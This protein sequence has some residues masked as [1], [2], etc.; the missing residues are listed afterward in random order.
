MIVFDNVTKGFW[1]RRQYAPI[2]S[3]LTLTL[4]TGKSLAL[5]G[6]NGSGKTTLMQMIAGTMRPDEGEIWSDD[7]ISWPVGTGGSFHRN[8]TGAQNTRFVARVYGIDTDELAAFVE[9]FA[10]LGRQFHAPIRTYSAGMRSR[11]AFGISMGIP[12]GTYLVDEVTAVGDQ[13][14]KRKSQAVFRD[15]MAVSSA[16]M[17]SHD[18]EEL[19]E[20]CNGAL[21]LHKGQLQYFDDLNEGIEQHKRNMA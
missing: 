16:I 9:D 15:R 19:Q 1:V 12:F 14:F 17:V 13:R 5:M 10:E 6:G 8:L 2:V 4:P 11:L 7:S 3:N 18:L 20:F 21:V